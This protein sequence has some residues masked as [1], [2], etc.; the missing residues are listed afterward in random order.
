MAGPNSSS[1][2]DLMDQQAG[3]P[4]PNAETGAPA[5]HLRPVPSNDPA[6]LPRK[7]RTGPKTPQGKARMSRNAMRFG[8]HSTV[9]LIPGERFEDW[10]AHRAGMLAS[11]EPANYLETFLVERMVSESWC[12]MNRVTAYEVAE[13]TRANKGS[14]V[15]R[16][17]PANEL[18][19]VQRYEARLTKQFYQAMHELEALQKQRR[20]EAA[21]LARLDVQGVSEP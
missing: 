16:L 1:E 5:G 20:G 6:A 3:T 18:D 14:E 17:P 9:P 21:P 11:V 7:K 19:K 2:E 10:Q 4:D 15:F 12:L 8:I 13:F